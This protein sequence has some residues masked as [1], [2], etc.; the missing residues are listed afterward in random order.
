MADTQEKF[1]SVQVL[2]IDPET[3]GQRIDNYLLGLLRGI[4]RS[5]VYRIIRK[6]EVRINKGRIRADYRLQAGDRIRI[7]PLRLPARGAVQQP[8]GE[9]LA[10]LSKAILFEDERLLVIDKPSGIAVHGGSGLRYG[11]IEALRALRPEAPYL[12]LVHRLDRDTSGCLL[13]A[14]RRSAL[15]T[16]HEL[17]RH[18]AVDKRY[19]ALL[20]GEWTGRAREV[21]AALRKNTL[22]SGERIVRVDV[23]GKPARTRFKPVQTLWAATLVEARL[24]T[25]RTHQIRVHAAHIGMPVVGDLKYGDDTVNSLWRKRGVDRLFLHAHSVEFRWPGEARS[26]KIQ[27]PLEPRLEAAVDSS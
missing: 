1:S 8:G 22:R 17:L 20:A 25:G 21:K 7:P 11:V 4:P 15:R 9:V 10:R 18:G 16:L 2:T 26:F 19:L 13:I 23:E 14:K 12:E 6:G 24:Y 27:A 5:H 3:S